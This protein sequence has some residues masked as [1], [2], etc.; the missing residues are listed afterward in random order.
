M[1]WWRNMATWNWV[2]IGSGN[3]LLPDGTKPLP[4]PVD[5]SLVRSID[6]NLMAISPKIP[7]R[8]I[9]KITLKTIYPQFYLNF[10]GANELFYLQCLGRFS[11]VLGAFVIKQVA[12]V[13]HTPCLQNTAPKKCTSSD[14]RTVK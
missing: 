14:F 4:E 11:R 7:S 3:G 6:I 13:F 1:A 5:L 12:N 9:T 8:S 10:P 2:N